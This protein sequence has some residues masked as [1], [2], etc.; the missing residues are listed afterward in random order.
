MYLFS[1]EADDTVTTPVVD[2][3]LAFYQAAGV[4]AA[5]I[6]YVKTVDAGHAIVTNNSGDS[7]CAVTQPPFINDCDRAEPGTLA[8]HL[9]HAEAARIA[10]ERWHRDLRPARV[11]RLRPLQYSDRGYAYGPKSCAKDSCRVHVA[12]HGCRQGAAQIGD[13]YYTSTG[14]NEIAD[15]NAMIVVYPQVQ[16]SDP[17]P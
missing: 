7:S 15:T 3:T 5:N 10:P 1:G 6:K 9:R 16:V 14:Y 8:T 12:F 11:H 4:P 13:R 17:I 2:Q